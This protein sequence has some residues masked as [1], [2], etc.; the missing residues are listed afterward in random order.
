MKK[1]IKGEKSWRLFMA[2]GLKICPNCKNT[3]GVRTLT[4]P[5]CDYDFVASKKESNRLKRQ[6]EASEI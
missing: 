4:C 5:N 6:E 3:V 1:A 2:N